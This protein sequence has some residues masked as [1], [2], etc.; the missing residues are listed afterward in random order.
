M[1]SETQYTM[2]LFFKRNPNLSP[3]EFKTY[4]EANHAPMVRDIAKDAKGL[5]TYK[6]RYLDHAASDP[7]LGNPFTVFGEPAA[8][9]TVPYDMVNEV[10]FATKADAAEFSRIMYEIEEN[11]VKVLEDE[12]KLFVRGSMR[13]MIVET[14][15]S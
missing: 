1:S 13:G 14:I 8:A 7:S 5:V 4:Y 12:D 10:T 15:T 9:G 3:A 11:R 2:L 6:R